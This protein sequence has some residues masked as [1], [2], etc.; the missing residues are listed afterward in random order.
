MQF[1]HGHGVNQMKQNFSKTFL[2]NTSKRYSIW[3]LS[4]TFM[5]FTTSILQSHM[6][7]EL[8]CVRFPLL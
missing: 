4:D 1:F 5:I 6:T 3:L 7:F 8:K 2:K